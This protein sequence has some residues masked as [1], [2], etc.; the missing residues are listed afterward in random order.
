MPRLCPGRD[1]SSL[2]SSQ[3]L[4]VSKPYTELCYQKLSQPKVP[5]SQPW[6]LEP[7]SPLLHLLSI[8]H[9]CGTQSIPGLSRALGTSSEQHRGCP[10]RL[11]WVTDSWLQSSGIKVGREKQREPRGTLQGDPTRGGFQEEVIFKL[12]LER[13]IAIAWQTGLGAG[14]VVQAELRLSGKAQSRAGESEWSA[15][16]G[17]SRG[18]AGRCTQHPPSDF[19]G[20]PLPS[21]PPKGKAT[22]RGGLRT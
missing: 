4:L 9:L 17:G 11:R 13:C 14:R 20:S 7:T 3:A 10:L 21:S 12:R 18:E 8:K 2:Y 19:M 6:S 1:T 22:R 5:Y 16:G 15:R